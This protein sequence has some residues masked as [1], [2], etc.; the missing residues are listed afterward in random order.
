MALAY[1][2]AP[3]STTLQIGGRYQR[4]YEDRE[5]QDNMKYHEMLGVT[6]SAMYSFS[7]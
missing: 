3:A 5:I 2:I 1:Y 7:I 4:L 6:A